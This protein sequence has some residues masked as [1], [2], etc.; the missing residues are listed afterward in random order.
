MPPDRTLGD[1]LY[2]DGIIK[3]MAAEPTE[4]PM[5]ELRAEI[6]ALRSEIRD[7]RQQTTRQF[8]WLLTFVLGSILIPILRD[9]NR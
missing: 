7:F 9:L 8:Y 4:I 6:A 5:A 2:I 3:P 1:V